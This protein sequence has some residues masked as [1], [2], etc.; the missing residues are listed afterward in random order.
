MTKKSPSTKSPIDDYIG[1]QPAEIQPALKNMRAIIKNAAPNAK[2]VISYQLPAFKINTVL[3]YFAGF[4]N[5]VGFYPTP[6]VISH[7]EKQLSNYKHAKG[8][9]QFPLNKALPEQLIKRMVKFRLK[10]DNEYLKAKSLRYCRNGHTYYKSSECPVC[11]VC[12]KNRKPVAEF[13]QTFA[14]PARRALENAGVTN[15]TQL[16][17]FSEKELLSLHGMGP[18]SIPKLKLLLKR[19]GLSLKNK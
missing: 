1:R 6:S 2:E 11:P 15:L 16:A 4:K 9:V 3:V 17:Q 8:S 18:S 14:A 12:E 7:F 5:H 19:N 13:M 10:K